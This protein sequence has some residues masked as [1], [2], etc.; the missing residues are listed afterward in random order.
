VALIGKLPATLAYHSVSIELRRRR[1]DE[2]VELFRF[3]RT[4]H[5][6]Q[7]ARKAAR[8]AAD[9]ADRI[10]HADP[11]IPACLFN[12]VADNWRPLIAIGDAAGGARPARARQAAQTGIAAADDQAGVR[13]L[14]DIRAIFTERRVERLP[15]AELVEGLVALESRPWAEWKGGKPI[16][17]RTGPAIPP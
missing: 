11:D 2:P 8:W 14:L 16:T 4:G 3:D 10:R 7:L 6:D 9:S 1:P 17:A 13:L 15:S 12:R 5:L